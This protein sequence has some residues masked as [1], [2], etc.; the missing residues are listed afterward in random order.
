MSNPS[1]KTCKKMINE[2]K[3]KQIWDYSEDEVL[4][5][6]KDS[7]TAFNG[8][9]GHSIED[10]A[11]I[12]TKTTSNIFTILNTAG[13]KTAFVRQNEPNSFIAKK[14]EMVPI[15]WVARRL[16]TGSF[17]KR[18]PGVEEG[19]KFYPLKLET[20]YKDDANDDPQWSDEQ[21]ISAK[22]TL[23]G[24]QIDRSEI[25][26]MRRTTQTV[27]E[28]LEKYWATQDCVLVDMKIE[29]GISSKGDILVADVIDNDSWRLWPSGDKRLMKDKQVYRNLKE[30]TQSDL[31]VIKDNFQWVADRTEIMKDIRSTALVVILMGSKSDK[32]Y[33][34]K[35]SNYC[36]SLGLNS[37][38]RISSAH[39]ST[40][41]VLN[42]IAYYEATNS[43]VV[44]IAVA[45]RSNGLGLVLAANTIFPVINC[46]PSS[47]NLSR[48]IWSSLSLP[49]GIGCTTV[50]YPEAAAISAAH[51]FSLNDTSVWSKLK[52]K[53]L[54]NFITL[55]NDD[56]QL[57]LKQ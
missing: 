29:F 46:P 3:T 20:F 47:D 11:V 36:D 12:S 37:V 34:Q 57:N 19:T 43:Q 35:I 8:V 44:Y 16:A 2:G 10:K 54:N 14:C 4:I 28:I 45:G 56:K 50:I 17:L 55:K 22:F 27:F 39:K 41:D 18:F 6:S 38:L 49:S 52:A 40:E 53:Q 51:V 5:L 48:D 13:V 21:M 25:D 15:E 33:C 9:R 7:I 31:I 42:I 26:I 30:V 24:L 1:G 23:N 32:E